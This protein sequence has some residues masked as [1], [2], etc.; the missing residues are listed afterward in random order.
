[1]VRKYQEEHK[2]L[3]ND[4]RDLW[5]LRITAED[6]RSNYGGRLHA[7]G[8]NVCGLS[9]VPKGKVMGKVEWVDALQS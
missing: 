4:A 6:L 8:G 9:T 1:M 7:N 2:D 3:D 5:N